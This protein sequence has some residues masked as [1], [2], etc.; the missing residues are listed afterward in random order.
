MARPTEQQQCPRGP[1]QHTRNKTTGMAP[2]SATPRAS[3]YKTTSKAVVT[4]TEPAAPEPSRQNDDDCVFIRV[5]RERMASVH[6]GLTETVQH[7]VFHNAGPQ[8]PAPVLHSVP[9]QLPAPASQQLCG[10]TGAISY[11]RVSILQPGGSGDRSVD[12]V[13]TEPHLEA[14][15]QHFAW[16]LEVSGASGADEAKVLMDS[17]S[18]ITAISEELVKALQG[19]PGMTQTVLPQAFAGHEREVTSLSQECDIETQSCP[20]YLT[21]D[22]PWGSVRFTMPFIVLPGAGDVVI[23]EQKTLREKLGIDVM[24]QLKASVLKALGRPNGA[25]VKLTARLVSEPNDVAEL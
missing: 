21:I 19:Q 11:A 16:R 1:T 23:I 7:K 17:D 13:V 3:A 6:Y 10:D 12:T 5:P 15:T 4:E 18:G 20:L 22:T 8:N 9:V 2:A 25:G 14:L 24:A